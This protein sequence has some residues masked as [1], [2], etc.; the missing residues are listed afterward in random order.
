MIFDWSIRKDKCPNLNVKCEY[1]KYI[2]K[3]FESE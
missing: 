3:C 1:F 2:S